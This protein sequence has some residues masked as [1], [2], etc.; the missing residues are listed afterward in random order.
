MSVFFTGGKGLRVDRYNVQCDVCQQT[1]T[2]PLREGKLTV[3]QHSPANSVVLGHTLRENGWKIGPF[4]V[5]CSIC[6]GLPMT[7]KPSITDSI[8]TLLAWVIR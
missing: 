5:K 8:M 2:G 7:R 4:S 3:P 1:H 6:T